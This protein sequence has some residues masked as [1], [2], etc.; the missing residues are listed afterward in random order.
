LPFSFVVATAN[1]SRSE[2]RAA[3]ESAQK[4]QTVPMNPGAFCLKP[5]AV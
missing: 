5:R 2:K 4:R 1:G 3:L